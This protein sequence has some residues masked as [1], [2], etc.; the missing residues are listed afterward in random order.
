MMQ[1]V[2]SFILVGYGQTIVKVI[3]RNDLGKDEPVEYVAKVVGKEKGPDGKQRTEDMNKITEDS[4]I[5]EIKL[6]AK[7]R[8]KHVIRCYGAFENDDSWVIVLEYAQGGNVFDRLVKASRF[9]EAIAAHYIRDLKLDN[10]LIK[11]ANKNFLEDILL[12]SDFGLA[13]YSETKRAQKKCGSPMYAAPELYRLSKDELYTETVDIW[14]LGVSAYIV[15]NARSLYYDLKDILLL[16]GKVD[17]IAKKVTNDNID[18]VIRNNRRYLSQNAENFLLSCLNVNPVARASAETLLGHQ[19]FD[20]C[21]DKYLDQ[22]AMK[23]WKAGL[24]AVRAMEPLAKKLH[25]KQTL[26][27]TVNKSISVL[28]RNPSKPRQ[29]RLSEKHQHTNDHTGVTSSF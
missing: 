4:T 28:P 6:L 27:R 24:I 22:K 8:H 9:S 29:N 3:E 15:F 11:G 16:S 23:K 21:E 10:F 14:S 7:L 12:L 19:L 13:T 1:M 18:Y 25:D 20:S 26:K 17:Q 5:S 2:Q